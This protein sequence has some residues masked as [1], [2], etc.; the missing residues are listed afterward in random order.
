M[1][2]TILNQFL[3]EKWL[4]EEYDTYRKNKK[5]ENWNAYLRDHM[6]NIREDAKKYRELNK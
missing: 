2:T 6:K 1:K 4:L 5:R 3:I